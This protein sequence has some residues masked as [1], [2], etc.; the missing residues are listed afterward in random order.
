MKIFRNTALIILGVLVLSIV[1][2]SIVELNAMSTSTHNLRTAM[3]IASKYAL[4]SFEITQF[5]GLD[6]D[7][8]SSYD[9]SK[10]Q[11][12][13][14]YIA[15]LDSLEKQGRENGFTASSSDF[16]EIIGFLRDEVNSYDP[17]NPNSSVLGPFAFGWTYLE[18]TR[19]QKEFEDCLT[20]IVQANYNPTGDEVQSLAFSGTNVLRIKSVKVEITNGPKLVNLTSGMNPSDPVYKTYLK[21]FGSTKSDAVK[22]INGIN[23]FDVMYNYVITYEVKFTV[24]WEHHTVTPFFNVSGMGRKLASQY[25]DERNQI[26]IDMQPMVMTRQYAILN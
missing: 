10:P 14:A 17:S 19:L 21:L 6:D 8:G 4:E 26:K 12:K 25:V 18:E 3:T 13:N 1:F 2:S 11:Y 15:Y 16:Q 22:I 7:V 23:A 24:E 20:K 9:I 5:S